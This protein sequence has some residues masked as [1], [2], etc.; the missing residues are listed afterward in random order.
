MTCPLSGVFV[1]YCSLYYILNNSKTHILLMMIRPGVRMVFIGCWIQ[2]TK[3]TWKWKLEKLLTLVF[4]YKSRFSFVL[5]FDSTIQR[6]LYLSISMFHYCSWL[7]KLTLQYLI[8]FLSHKMPLSPIA[9]F[10]GSVLCWND[11]YFKESTT[12]TI[13]RPGGHVLIEIKFKS[14]WKLLANVTQEYSRR[15]IMLR[16][17]ACNLQSNAKAF[18]KGFQFCI[19]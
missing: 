15:D 9:P 10:C 3:E 17:S 14:V 11:A 1:K 2:M 18:Y 13:Q 6:A 16:Y 4:V 19:L 5:D 7:I 12:V 8:L